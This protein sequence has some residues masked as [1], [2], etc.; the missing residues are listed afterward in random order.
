MVHAAITMTGPPGLTLEADGH[1]R[2]EDILGAGERGTSRSK[3]AAHELMLGEAGDADCR[4]WSRMDQVA[5]LPLENEEKGP[6]LSGVF[7]PLRHLEREKR[8]LQW[9]GETFKQQVQRGWVPET[10][11]Y[12]ASGRTGSETAEGKVAPV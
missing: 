4:T 7:C 2:L 6:L 10:I 8:K 9:S 12:Y 5:F 3:M 11:H 1:K